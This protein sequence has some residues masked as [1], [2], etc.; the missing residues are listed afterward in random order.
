MKL[1]LEN[2]RKFLTEKQWADYNIPKGEWF[3]VPLADIKKQAIDNEGEIQIADELYDLI[4]AAYSKIGGHFDFQSA[5]DLPHDATNWLAVDLDDDPHPDALR[6]SKKK[7]PGLKMTVS[8]HDGNRKAIDAYIAKT[9]ELLL[10]GGYYGEMSKGIAHM[11]IKYHN[12]PYVNNQKDVERV[13][14]KT[15]EWVGAHPEG[16]YPSHNGW[17]VRKIGG[18]HEDMKILLGLPTG[19]DGV[20]KP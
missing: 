6:V 3:E 12:V 1:L 2:W 10:Q 7:P 19:I 4:D 9:A 5:G 13:L 8:G 11:M 14:G 16:K 20:E 15:V 17:Y 18:E